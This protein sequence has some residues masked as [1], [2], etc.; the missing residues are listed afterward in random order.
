[1]AQVTQTQSNVRG[2]YSANKGD[3]NT[4]GNQNNNK[5]KFVLP[6]MADFVIENQGGVLGAGEAA[7]R[8]YRLIPYCRNSGFTGRKGH[9]E[10][11]K[12]FSERKGHNRV[13]LY[14]LGGSG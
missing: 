7:P 12:R 11:V 5:F 3:K 6:S 13:A 9:V 4:Y 10:A 8:P 2:C 1:M 14:G